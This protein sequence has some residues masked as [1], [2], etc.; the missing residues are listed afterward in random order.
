M[1]DEEE[2]LL[3]RDGRALGLYAWERGEGPPYAM[4]LMV[5][6]EEVE[7]CS[8]TGRCDPVEIGE[9]IDGRL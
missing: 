6:S 1:G 7:D 5:L 9:E 4:A 8:R 3:L 2:L